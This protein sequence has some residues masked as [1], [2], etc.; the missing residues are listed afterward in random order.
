VFVPKADTT[1]VFSIGPALVAVRN[2]GRLRPLVEGAFVGLF[3]ASALGLTFSYSERFTRPSHD[4]FF[5][6][7]YRLPDS[8]R[9]AVQRRRVAIVNDVIN[10]GS[11][12]RGTFEDLEMSGADIVAIGTL[13]TLGGAAQEFAEA[14]KVAL[15]SLVCLPNP[16]W[17]PP[18]CPLCTKGVPLED[19]ARFGSAFADR[20]ISE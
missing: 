2:R 20:A 8:L 17:S 19:V 9:H 14:K 12:V 18:A 10:P 15:E 6:A 5:P 11:A 7:G 13:L 4:G 16:L 3:V 1:I